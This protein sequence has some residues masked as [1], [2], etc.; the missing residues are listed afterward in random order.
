MLNLL[1][2]SKMKWRSPFRMP[3]GAAKGLAVALLCLLSI[4]ANA[5]NFTASLDRETITLGEG[6]NLTLK[7]DGGEFRTPPALPS[8]P[9]TR[10][11]GPSR[12]SSFSMVNGVTSSSTALT[13]FLTPTQLGPI[14]IPAITIDVDGQKLQSAPLK[15][16][17]EK[18]VA[19]P[20]VAKGIF[21]RLVLP[22]T[23]VYL[24]E[25]LPLEIQLYEQQA[26]LSEM[27]HFKEEGFT[28]GKMQQPTQ[29]LTVFNNQRYR[30]TTFKTFVV[31]AKAGK[32][33]IGPV[34][35][36]MQV[37]RP[38]SRRTIFG[39]IVDW[40]QVT[41][42]SDPQTLDVLPLPK[43]NMPASFGGAV[44]NYSVSVNVSPTNV[45]TGDPITVKVQVTGR[46]PLDSM[47]LPQQADWNQFKVY[48]PTSD[49]QFA[50]EMGMSGVKT[51]ALTV[52]PE[53]TSIKELPPFSFSYFDPDQKEYRTVTQPAV[54]LTIRPSAATQAPSNVANTGGATEG[55]PSPTK[56][57]LHI[58]PRLGTLAQI[59][60]PLVQQPWF[61]ALQG[62]P[63]FAWISL[64]VVR[65]QKEK[66]ANNPRLRRQRQVE[67]T[68]RKGMEELRQTAQAN[69]AEDFYATVFRL[70]QEQIGERL[71]LPASAITESVVEERLRPRKVA[72]ET[73]DLT[74]DLFLACNQARYARQ[75]SNEQL[76][77]LIPTVEKTLNQL[78]NIQA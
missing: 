42:E 3:G 74:R 28:L 7:L 70:L 62:I 43:E 69:Q 52:V 47:T 8:L 76:I 25:L 6:V 46:G 10:I 44:G 19:N 75:S 35:M 9:N 2:L 32:I 71:D 78:R 34:S 68:I 57:I 67:Q 17:V 55:N 27:P 36:A 15:L 5:A 21:L 73:L 54:P 49:V 29:A 63:V 64:F 14:D 33:E 23:Q 39:E 26:R 1:G 11:Q 37:P 41:I 65:K 30:V 51:F 53:S 12:S 50:D 13:Y 56:D 20:A 16:N 48:P 66:L 24:G 4:V 22:K 58:K 60:A 72:E 38:D 40:Q 61:L 45:A 77:S 59:Q 31:P 18:A